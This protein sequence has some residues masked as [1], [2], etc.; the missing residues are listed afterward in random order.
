MTRRHIDSAWG[1]FQWDKPG[2]EEVEWEPHFGS[3]LSRETARWLR[4]GGVSNYAAAG[5]TLASLFGLNGNTVPVTAW[6]M[7]ELVR[8]IELFNVVWEEAMSAYDDEK[9]NAQRLINLPLLQS[10]YVEIMR[11]HVSFNVTRKTTQP[12]VV[13]GYPIEKGALMQACSQIAHFD[14]VWGVKGHPA[15]DFWARRHVRYDDDGKAQFAMKGRP[16]S[17][18]PYGKSPL[19]F[20]MLWECF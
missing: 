13:D 10:L 14:D 2:A 15:S 17:F 5:H 3:L 18:F 8:D 9:I 19:I 4:Q 1:H 11:L 20:V 16:S 12:I 7:I 6:A